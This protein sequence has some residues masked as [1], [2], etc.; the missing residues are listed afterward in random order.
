MSSLEMS[1]YLG[2]LAEQVVELKLQEGDFIEVRS[3]QWSKIPKMT[4]IYVGFGSIETEWGLTVEKYLIFT[5]EGLRE[6]PEGWSIG[7]W[8]RIE[9][10]E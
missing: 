9:G 10:A 5:S 4:G 1:N 7:R 2:P 6:I 8:A 3:P